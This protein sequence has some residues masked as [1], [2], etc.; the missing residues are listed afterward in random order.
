MADDVLTET[1]GRPW[2]KRPAEM[3]NVSRPQDPFAPNEQAVGRA[4]R[5]AGENVYA[6]VA[7][8]PPPSIC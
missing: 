7:M 2:H 8:A 1:Y 4:A 5:S 3:R 6:R